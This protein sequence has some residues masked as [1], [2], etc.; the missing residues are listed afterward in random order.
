MIEVNELDIKYI[1][2]TMGLR[3]AKPLRANDECWQGYSQVYDLRQFGE[4][5]IRCV[6]DVIDSNAEMDTKEFADWDKPTEMYVETDMD[7]EE[8][9]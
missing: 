8:I 7:P 5:V 2:E 9:N 6:Y 3:S 1:W 4:V